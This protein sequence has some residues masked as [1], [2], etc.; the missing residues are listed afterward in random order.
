VDERLDEC[1]DKEEA[2]LVLWLGLMCSQSRPEARPSM[3]QACQ[4]LDGELEMQEEAVLVF[5]DVDSVDVGS[6]AFLTW[7]SCN[8]MSGGSLLA[9][10]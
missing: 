1:Y 10:R 5:S 6:S 9:G 2:R 7:S 4:Y 8:T 3:R